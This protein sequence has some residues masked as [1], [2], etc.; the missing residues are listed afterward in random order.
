MSCFSGKCDLYD[1][2]M[3][4]KMYPKKD[5]PNILESDEFECF[6]IF[7]KRTNGIIYQHKKVEVTELNQ[8]FIE[9]KCNFLEL[10]L[11][12][13]I[14][15]DARCKEGIRLKSW[16]TYK[17]ANVEYKNLKELNKKGVYVSLP[18]KFDTILDLI[19]Y[20]PY[21]ISCCASSPEGET[22]YI[23]KKS[24][25]D[26]QIDSYLKTGR[27]LDFLNHY[28]KE[29]QNHYIEIVKRLEADKNGL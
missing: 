24:Y 9:S 19:P 23:S 26:E 14:I 6:E 12:E 21:I 29:L 18:I 3:M 1:H 17:Y 25:I 10:I 7:K 27:S 5:N 22:I 2:M 13:E 16:Y 20:Y 15:P 8:H 4:E 28:K 11:H